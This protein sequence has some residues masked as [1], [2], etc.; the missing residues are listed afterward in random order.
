MYDYRGLICRLF[1]F[2]ARSNKKNELHLISCKII[3]SGIHPDLLAGQ[4][5][6]APVSSAWYLK[7]YGIDPQLATKHLPINEAIRKALE[8]VMFLNQFKKP[9]KVS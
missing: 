3:K 4:I 8:L 5:N 1:G 2:S 6:D 9:G 7:L